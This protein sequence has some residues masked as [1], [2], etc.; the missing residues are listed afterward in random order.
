MLLPR[1][2]LVDS[3]RLKQ[4]KSN[5]KQ[6]TARQGEPAPKTLSGIRQRIRIATT[7]DLTR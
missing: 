4:Y 7:A 6:I 5:N 1:F 2:L 3:T